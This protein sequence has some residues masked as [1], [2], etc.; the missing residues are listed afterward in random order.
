MLKLGGLENSPPKTDQSPNKFRRANNVTFTNDGYITPRPGFNASTTI[1]SP[2]WKRISHMTTY[3]NG[4]LLQLGVYDSGATNN[5]TT[6]LNGTEI[7]RPSE[8]NVD[9]SDSVGISNFQ[10]QSIETNGTKYILSDVRFDGSG[11]SQ[12]LKY[13]GNE[14]YVT[15]SPMPKVNIPR[16]PGTPSGT[17]KIK[18][19]Q[20]MID[21]QG[22]T[23][24]SEAQY[25]EKTATDIAFSGIRYLN[26][27]FFFMGVAQTTP[28]SLGGLWTSLDGVNIESC[29]CNVSFAQPLIAGVKDITYGNG[30]YVGIVNGSPSNVFIYSTDG[31]SWMNVVPPAVSSWSSVTYGNGLFVAVSTSSG[32]AASSPDG[33]TWT[34]RTTPVANAWSVVHWVDSLSIFVS[35]SSGAGFGG[36]MSSTNGTTWTARTIATGGRTWTSITDD[37]SGTI[38]AVAVNGAAN[39]VMTSTNGTTWNARTTPTAAE[40]RQVT[41]TGSTFISVASGGGTPRAMVSTDGTTWSTLAF[42]T[43]SYYGIAY[44]ASGILLTVSFEGNIRKSDSIGVTWTALSNPQ[45]INLI[46]M[47]VPVATA[48]ANYAE[49]PDQNQEY[50]EEEAAG[51][52]DLYFSGLVSYDAGNSRLTATTEATNITSSSQIGA[53]VIQL[54]TVLG[55]EPQTLAYQVKSISPL[56]FELN[57]KK[58]NNVTLLWD[59]IAVSDD[60]YDTTMF[61]CRRFTSVWSSTASEGVYYFRG[62]MESVYDTSLA[63]TS[64]FYPEFTSLTTANTLIPAEKYPFFI[65]GTLQDWYDVQANRE[66][67]NKDGNKYVSIT[68]YSDLILAAT[69]DLIFFSDTSIGGSIEMT[70]GV[71]KIGDTE[72]GKITSICGTKD[73]LV[74]SRERKVYYVT[75][76][77]DTGNYRIQ[78]LSNCSIGSYSNNSMLEVEGSIIMLTTSGVWLIEGPQATKISEGISPHFQTNLAYQTT[79]PESPDQRVFDLRGHPVTAYGGI[80]IDYPIISFYDAYR[81]TVGFIDGSDTNGGQALILHLGSMD[82]ATWDYLSIVE[83]TSISAIAAINGVFSIGIF[84]DWPED[85]KIAAENKTVF[86]PTYDYIGTSPALL[87]TTWGCAGEPSLEKQLTQFKMFGFITAATI[88]HYENWDGVTSITSTSYLNSLGDTKYYH[89]QRLNSSKVL[90]VSVEMSFEQLFLLE[91]VEIEFN[92]IQQGMKK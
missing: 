48:T 19:I 74:V 54:K 5:V 4:G 37:G 6:A 23:V 26:G 27:R 83:S 39:Q 60:S 65:S 13:D 56:A 28:V 38:V 15:G 12:L 17:A 55:V 10:P 9:T 33:I 50:I 7:P 25:S 62:M 3:G 45:V 43:E 59:T 87:A 35:L 81:R 67:F 69:D 58:F 44:S 77:L 82:F 68:L 86:S 32:H 53:W 76:Q 14:I 71:A 90:A 85:A 21:M 8:L 36:A 2:A 16:G 49:F 1:G 29:I 40:W 41:W 63:F 80:G 51:Q 72:F 88:K 30:V 57:I 61:A 24:S 34:L 79:D 91:G 47:G 52:Q 11:N 75:G 42:N 18:L 73:F 84:E 31:K 20:H 78:E 92:P 70:N 22:N 64:Y 89:K 66:P 46:P